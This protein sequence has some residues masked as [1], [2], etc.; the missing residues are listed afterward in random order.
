MENFSKS[1][2][3]KTLIEGMESAFPASFEVTLKDVN[4]A[5]RY[6]REFQ[7]IDGVEKVS[8]YKDLIAKIS[9][10]S[11]IVK[12]AGS[13]VVAILVMISIINISNTIRLTVYARRKKLPLRKILVHR[14]W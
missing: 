11:R 5:E 3:D 8:F 7:K 9:N 12:Y 10:A 6:V 1:L 4:D 14:I 2:D 13:I